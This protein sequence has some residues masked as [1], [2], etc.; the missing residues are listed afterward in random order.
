M[1]LRTIKK[2][3]EYVLGEFIDDCTLFIAINPDKATEE[4]A[5]IIDEAVDLYNDLKDKVNKPQDP[6][7]AYYKGIRCELFDGL[8]KL[9]EKLSTAVSK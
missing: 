2:D 7:A 1:N 6:K 9:C 5:N 3:I 4:I 8:D